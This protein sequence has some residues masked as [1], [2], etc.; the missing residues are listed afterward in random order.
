MTDTTAEP[1]AGT[2]RTP[3]DDADVTRVMAAL[4]SNGMT[5]L[6]AADAAEA[7]R[8][9]L[10]VIPAGAQVHSASSKSLAVAGIT[11]EIE[12]SGRYEAV[13]P[14]LWRMD[15]ETQFDEMRRLNTA[16]DVMLGS[17]QAVTEG[18]A[19]VIASATGSQLG[20]YAIG[21]GKLILVVGTHKIVAD[22][23]EAFRR[24]HEYVLPLEDARAREEHGGHSGVNKVLVINR[25]WVPGRVSL[26][27]VDEPLGF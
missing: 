21:A 23:D 17:V 19:L 8:L 24:I 22:L 10:D 16:P 15:R 20:P 2:W 9:V 13:R 11:A 1:V 5:A 6:R 3:A 7:K 18:G 25:E 12:G 4:E 27:F 26:V 14:R